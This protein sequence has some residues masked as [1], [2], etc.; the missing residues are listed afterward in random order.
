MRGRQ[1]THEEFVQEFKN[2]FPYID[3]LSKY[4]NC[5]EKILLHC[6]KCG[7]TWLA[8]AIADHG[9][10]KCSRIKSNEKYLM[11]LHNKNIDINPL[12]EYQTANTKILHKCLK[13]G[14]EWKVAPN[15][16]LTGGGCPVCNKSSQVFIGIN[17][18]NTV[19]PEISKMLLNQEEGKKYACHSSKK[20]DW[21]CPY[22]H[23][24]VRQKSIDKVTSRGLKCNCCG[25]GISIPN[26]FVA[27]ILS[28]LGIEYIPEKR[29][30]WSNNKRYD[31]YIPQINCICEVNGNQ[32][33]SDRQFTKETTLQ[34]QINNDNEK[35]LLAKNNNIKNYII[36]DA[37]HSEFNWLK[38]NILNSELSKLF[39]LNNLDFYK[40][41]LNCQKSDVINAVNLWNNGKNT[42]QIAQLLKIKPHT[43]ITY[44]YR[45]NDLGICNYRGIKERSKKVICLATNEIF[46]T[47]VDA[48]RKYN[49]KKSSQIC[50][51]CQHKHKYCGKHPITKEKLIWQY[52]DEFL[53]E[54]QCIA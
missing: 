20:L 4:V 39:N 47:P 15:Q 46:E 44:L 5:K 49:I 36:I 1:K 3:V 54:H 22:C 45:G 9:C 19:Y 30:N 23:N 42:K 17:D 8:R 14:Y 33:Y 50:A 10:D 13:C 53:K 43:V 28:E 18:L 11:D 27:N 25:S 35:F 24:I 34:N 2:N 51:C 16:L 29:F 7:N 12:Q 6:N 37:R 52:Y 38:E 48:A 31:F 21:I 26:K 41:F 40:C 32:H